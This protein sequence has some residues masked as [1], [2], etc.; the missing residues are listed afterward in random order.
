MNNITKNRDVINEIIGTK[1][2]V[3][4]SSFCL[5]LIVGSRRKLPSIPN[6]HVSLLVAYLTND[7]PYSAWNKFKRTRQAT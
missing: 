6:V 4:S 2:S 1:I 5:R 7:V 3:I